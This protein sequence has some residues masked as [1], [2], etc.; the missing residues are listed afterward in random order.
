M[1]T[2]YSRGVEGGKRESRRLRLPP[3]A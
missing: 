3:A 2:N 1:K